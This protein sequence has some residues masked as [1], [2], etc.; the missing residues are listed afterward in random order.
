MSDTHIAMRKHMEEEPSDE[1]LSFERHGLLF[2]AV[3]I[4]PPPEGD[5][6]VLELEDTVIAD[7][8]PVSIP[9]EVLQNP[10]GPGKRRFAIDDPFPMREPSSEYLKSTRIFE[11]CDLPGKDKF[12]FLEALLEIV[13]ELVSEQFSHNVY[14]NEEPFA[15]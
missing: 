2:I 8:D 14:G 12:S 11:M 4:I 10:F 3:S 7:C 15:A 9:A 1:L 13:Q 6:T 5:L